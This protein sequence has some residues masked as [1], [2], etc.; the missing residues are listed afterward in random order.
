MVKAASSKQMLMERGDIN[1][2]LGSLRLSGWRRRCTV[3]RAK[4]SVIIALVVT[5]GGSVW[6]KGW[7]QVLV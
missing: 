5:L 4:F 3:R 1:N 7:K 6:R 2:F